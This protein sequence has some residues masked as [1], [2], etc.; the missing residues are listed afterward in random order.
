MSRS[1]CCEVGLDY[2]RLDDLIQNCSFLVAPPEFVSWLATTSSNLIYRVLCIDKAG[3]RD[4]LG[5]TNQVQ[6]NVAKSLAI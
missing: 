3:A 4:R 1:D 2:A 6:Q 5:L